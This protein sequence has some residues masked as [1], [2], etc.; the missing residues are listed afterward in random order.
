MRTFATIRA[1]KSIKLKLGKLKSGL[2]FLLSAFCFSPI[3]WAQSKAPPDYEVKAAFLVNFPKYVEWPADASA[4]TNKPI[5]VAC[6]GESK[7]SDALRKIIQ[8][9]PPNGRAIVARVIATEDESA[10]CHILFIGDAERRRLPAVLEKLKGESVL[11]IG[12]SEGFL[13]KGGIINLAL[14][15]RKVRVDVNLDAAREANLKIRSQLLGV[16]D[17]VKGKAN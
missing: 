8:S 9:R 3:G 1:G 2:Y 14:R 5:I 17:V 4:D 11:V 15:D 13:D 12:E 16:A 7:V 10:G 6:L